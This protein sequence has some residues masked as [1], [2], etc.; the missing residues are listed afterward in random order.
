M[1]TG[2]YMSCSHDLLDN[3]MDMGFFLLSTSGLYKTTS[4]DL[5]SSVKGVK[6]ALIRT[7]LTV[8]R[9]RKP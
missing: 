8:A 7:S 6:G 5:M 2:V 1:N 3:S 9:I 4:G